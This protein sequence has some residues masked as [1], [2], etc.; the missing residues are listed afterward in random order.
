MM[1]SVRA[2]DGTQAECLARVAM[3]RSRDTAVSAFAKTRGEA[4]SEGKL[5]RE[6]TV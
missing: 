4:V 2:G 3:A 6:G 5:F 1:Q